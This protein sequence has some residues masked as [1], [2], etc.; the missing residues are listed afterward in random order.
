MITLN[1]IGCRLLAAPDLKDEND[2]LLLADY[3]DRGEL[4]CV[5]LLKEKRA[6]ESC[7]FERTRFFHYL[8]SRLRTVG[9]DGNF[10]LCLR[11]SL[12]NNRRGRRFGIWNSLSRFDGIDVPSE[13]RIAQ[14]FVEESEDV[15][16]GHGIFRISIDDYG[17]VAGFAKPSSRGF[18]IWL[19]RA[20]GE[21]LGELIAS[22]WKHG[23]SELE[24]VS[25]IGRCVARNEGSLLR[26]FGYL[27][28]Q[29]FGVDCIVASRRFESL[30][31]AL[32]L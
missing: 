17:A 8:D 5:S 19:E 14:I 30:Y 27:D 21:I 7:S 29:D 32:S 6:E 18:V 25:K 15:I 10:Y 1:D 16:W 11:K 23:V 20:Q 22:G 4:S 3:L 12:P 9:S 28:S 24:E 26:F 13:R 31:S 2:C